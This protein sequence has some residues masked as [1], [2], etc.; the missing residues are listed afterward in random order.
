VALHS[1]PNVIR[2]LKIPDFNP[3][4]FAKTHER[5]KPQL[6]NK[7]LAPDAESPE[8]VNYWTECFLHWWLPEIWFGLYIALTHQAEV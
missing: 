4:S 8:C 7:A 6:E 2:S 5:T 1:F 3:A